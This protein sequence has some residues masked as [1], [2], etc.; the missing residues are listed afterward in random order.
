MAPEV[1]IRPY[2]VADIPALFEAARESVA[3]VHPWLP[4]CHPDY[5]IEESEE[6]V[7]SQV[8]R[9]R[10]GAEYEFV[11]VD[12]KGRFLGGCGL[13][14]VDREQ[15]R[16]NLGYW[17]RSTAAGRGIAPEA[18]RQLTAWAREN[19]DLDRLEIVCAV[20]NHRS[21]RVAEKA[22][23]LREGLERGRLELHGRK[24]DA[25]VFVLGAAAPA[26]GRT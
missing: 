3:E 5:R 14:E 24:V 15:R 18:V 16:A 23:A 21:Q 11:I 6:W 1:H 4:W 17:V 25:V 13:N 10:T 2:A 12:D 7:R 9:F 8:E 26:G 19:T 22:G 20:G